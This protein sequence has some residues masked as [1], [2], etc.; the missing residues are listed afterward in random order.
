MVGVDMGMG[1]VL[2]T[3]YNRGTEDHPLWEVY[4][5]IREWSNDYLGTFDTEL[6][7]Q[8]K[9]F[10]YNRPVMRG[11]HGGEIGVALRKLSMREG[12]NDC[13]RLLVLAAKHCP[14]D[15]HDWQEIQRIADDV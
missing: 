7:A 2:I 5:H 13:D 4:G 3:Y 1:Y 12:R 14:R 10:N 15:H 9:A 11:T 8:K 6:E